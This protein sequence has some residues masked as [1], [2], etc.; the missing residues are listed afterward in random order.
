MSEGLKA[1][2]HLGTNSLAFGPLHEVTFD[3]VA[4]VNASTSQTTIQARLPL[5]QDV[6]VV[7]VAANVSAISGSPA[8]Q[9]VYGTG[10]PGTTA[11]LPSAPDLNNPIAPVT[12]T[13][14]SAPVCVPSANTP[15]NIATAVPE[16]VFEQ[17][18]PGPN[19][20]GAG[21][22]MLTLRVLSGPGDTASNLK[23]SLLVRDIDPYPNLP[24][25]TP[26]SNY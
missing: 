2:S 20:G 23:V 3:N 9:V 5:P 24:G 26:F 6:Q 25:T 14:F 15:L 21:A 16:A 19:P 1:K 11:P 8:I 4:T 7:K 12:T 17:A 18:S 10:T 22:G 13:L